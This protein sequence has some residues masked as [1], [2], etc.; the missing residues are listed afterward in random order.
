MQHTKTKLVIGS[1]CASRRQHSMLLAASAAAGVLA[2]SIGFMSRANAQSVEWNGSTSSDYSTGANWVGGSTPGTTNDALF[3]LTAYTNQPNVGTNDNAAGLIFGDGTTA[4]AAV[5]LTGTANLTVGADGIVQNAGALGATITAP[6]TLTSPVITN[7]SSSPLTFNTSITTT[8]GI[9]IAGTGV[10]QFNI[11]NSPITGGFT[12]N[13]GTA[14]FDDSLFY[15]NPF[16]TSQ[17]F[18]VNTGGTL[19]IAQPHALGNYLG[20]NAIVVNGG[21]LTANAEQ[22]ISTL[23][24]NGATVNGSSELRTEYFYGPPVITV[25]SNTSGSTIS[26]NLATENSQNFVFNVSSGATSG[27]DLLVSGAITNSGGI[28]VNGNGTVSLTSYYSNFTGNVTVNGGTLL[29]SGRDY[30]GYGGLG[31][32]SVTGRIITVN[33]GANLVFNTN[34]AFGPGYTPANLPTINISGGT[35]TTNRYQP[36]GTI[37][38][39]GGSLVDASTDN[40]GYYG[41]QFLGGINV[42]GSSP[43]T[44]SSS[45]GPG[46]SLSSTTVITVAS[47]GSSGPD[48]TISSTLLDPSADFGGSGGLDKEGPGTLSLTSANT[49]TGNVTVGGGTLITS[50]RDYY[51]YGGLG[52]DSVP[53]RVITINSG[54][55]LILNINNVMSGGAYFPT[56][57]IS[58]GTVTTNY[59]NTIGNVN[60]NG[61]TL[62]DATTDS[63]YQGYYFTGN[64]NVTGTSPSTIT[65]DITYDGSGNQLTGFGNHLSGDVVITVA[66]TGSTGP[67]LTISAALNDGPPGISTPGGL[68]KEGPGSMLLSVINNFS[69]NFNIGAGTV[70]AE[71]ANGFSSSVGNVDTTGRTITIGP[72]AKLVIQD[73]PN[74]TYTAAKGYFTA[75]WTYQNNPEFGYYPVG[76]ADMFS[77]GIVGYYGYFNGSSTM[78]SLVLNGGT[79][80]STRYTPLGDITLNSGAVLTQASLDTAHYLV[81][82]EGNGYFY[83]GYQF[84]GDV[85]VGGTSPSFITATPNAYVTDANGIGGTIGGDHLGP[86]TTFNVS[87]TTS[88]P[89]TVDLVVSAPLI[90]QSDDFNY[91]TYDDGTDDLTDYEGQI[92]TGGLTKTGLGI[93]SLSASNGYTGDTNINAGTLIL[94][95]TGTLASANININSGGT[96]TLG[97][98]TTGLSLI[99]NLTS[100][101]N[102]NSGGLMTVAAPTAQTARQLVV[103]TGGLNI[104]GSIG[105]WTGTVDITSNDLD[106]PGGNLTTINDQVKSGFNAAAGGY[107]N[108][109]GITSTTAANDSTYLTAVGVI[110]NND[111]HGN[112]IYGSG[113]TLGLFDGYNPAL[114]DVLVKYTYYGDANLD[115]VVDGS[116]Y[117]LIDNG[118]N[119]HLTGW[120]NGDF[121]YDGVVDGSDYT[122]IDN[123]YNMQGNS[124]GTL[125][126]AELV[127][128]TSEQIAGTAAVPEPA[129]LGMLAITGIAMLGRRRRAHR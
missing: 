108:G 60:L 102:V 49:F 9:T 8:A 51:G 65:D 48:L 30:Y 41:Y 4:A 63:G 91:S 36:V 113:T 127:A 72:G 125:N 74:D 78:P 95:E 114:T 117:S 71:E 16:A 119:N 68:D 116:D 20:P 98:T 58:G 104:A 87:V 69:G 12:V 6:L 120:F 15:G 88:V 35:V 84:I 59:F 81:V 33:T 126:A 122:L 93:M 21:T 54:A 109:T 76:A 101:V 19:L 66:S 106:I 105:A 94:T 57:N 123:T 45:T 29:D 52:S 99:R 79:L 128:S 34:N 40:G 18:T 89:G 75:P 47:T 24:L 115:G 70:I 38:L 31:S 56:L 111:G 53:G 85:T 55:S 110:V 27:V 17:T 5:T 46:D 37:N 97:A 77:Y 3:D 103:F 64:I 32:D 39:S 10:T 1:F 13:S 90:N 107:W 26:C 73:N 50:G 118:F 96:F 2:A 83:E 28:V 62:V 100:V 67:D 129:S 23:E 44:I 7:N 61:G 22:Y 124:L 14:E 25:D 82:G 42:T 121:N 80:S 112:A 11:S 92:A 86:N 43:S